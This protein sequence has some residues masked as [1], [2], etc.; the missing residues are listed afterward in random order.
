MFSSWLAGAEHLLLVPVLV[1]I[2]RSLIRLQRG[3][4]VLLLALV[5]LDRLGP[6][7]MVETLL[8]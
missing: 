5:A 6:E 1:A 4:T 2:R 7:Q 8:R 3:L